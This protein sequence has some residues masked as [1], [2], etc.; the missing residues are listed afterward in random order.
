[1]TTRSGVPTQRMALAHKTGVFWIFT[2]R[3]VCV[4]GRRPS[5]LQEDAEEGESYVMRRIVPLLQVRVWRRAQRP[6]HAVCAHTPVG[7]A[8]VACGCRWQPLGSGA[9]GKDGMQKHFAR[10]AAQLAPG[11]DVEPPP[12][13]KALPRAR[14]RSCLVTAVMASV[15]EAGRRKQRVDADRGRSD[16]E[17]PID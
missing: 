7:P 5:H 4:D 3:T 14:R 6:G 9:A 17:A 16:Q 2:S 13:T 12:T 11:G 15:M 1:M 8:A 10:A